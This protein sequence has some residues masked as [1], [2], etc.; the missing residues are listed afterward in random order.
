MTQIHTVPEDVLRIIFKLLSTPD[1]CRAASV[2]ALWRRIADETT[3]AVSVSLSPA[4]PRK[5]QATS[6]PLW[7]ER[8]THRLEHLE[9]QGGNSRS[10]S[11]G[12]LES[13]FSCSRLTYLDVRNVQVGLSKTDCTKLPVSLQYLSISLATPLH[14][15]WPVSHLTSL[16][17]AV[18]EI[19][20]RSF[21]ARRPVLEIT[22][23]VA[24]HKELRTLI[25][26]GEVTVSAEPADL[27]QLVSL[28]T[29]GI[30]G[31]I[32]QRSLAKLGACPRAMRML[33]ALPHHLEAGLPNFACFPCL[34]QL[35]AASYSTSGPVLSGLG[36]LPHLR[37]AIIACSKI[38]LSEPLPPQLARVQLRNWAEE[39]DISLSAFEGAASLDL[40]CLAARKEVRFHPSADLESRGLVIF[41]TRVLAVPDA[42]PLELVQG[43]QLDVRGSCIETMR[44]ANDNLWFTSLA[45]ACQLD[46]WWESLW[47]N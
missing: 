35:M 30:H 9:L 23:A 32:S 21:D 29:L 6:F 47:P 8:H 19:T 22:P 20:D 12:L 24:A 5:T 31:F 36:N 26:D 13:I 7:F 41:P 1:L 18:L 39:L 37:E 46:A 42:G 33:L 40:L 2:C 44:F 45:T 4:D 25:L 11:C 16:K 14:V 3:S 27:E 38:S 43:M 17:V 34:R 28:E 10:L 15:A